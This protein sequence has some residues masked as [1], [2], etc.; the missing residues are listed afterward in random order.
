MQEPTELII[1]QHCDSLDKGYFFIGNAK[2]IYKGGI[3]M[4]RRIA[5]V[6]M[7]DL[8]D[9]V[10]AKIDNL[11]A[12]KDEAIRL[13]TERVDEEFADREKDLRT[14]LEATSEIITEPD[15]E[16][17]DT[18]EIETPTEEVIE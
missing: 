13:A 2:I 17:A 15:E 1:Y 12:E 8:F 14:M 10:V 4:E 16:I 9:M 5:K 6:G 3:S 11:N 18:E 7:E